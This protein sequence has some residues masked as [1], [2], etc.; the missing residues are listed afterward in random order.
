MNKVNSGELPEQEELTIL[1]DAVS[2]SALMRW[3]WMGGAAAILTTLMLRNTSQIYW[4]M[5]SFFRWY[6]T[7]LVLSFLL[8]RKWIG[9]KFFDKRIRKKDVRVVTLVVTI[10]FF[11]AGHVLGFFTISLISTALKG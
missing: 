5:L 6:M 11:V 4:F 1:K 3:F 7:V 8:Y 2:F 10:S 9:I